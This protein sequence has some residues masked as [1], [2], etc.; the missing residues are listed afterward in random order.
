MN[1]HSRYYVW[2][3]SLGAPSLAL[4]ISI[5]VAASTWERVRTTPAKRTIQV[6]GSATKR[7]ISDLI[8]WKAE[9]SAT[10]P[11]RVAAYRDLPMARHDM[12]VMADPAGQIEAFRRFV[13]LERELLELLGRKLEQDQAMAG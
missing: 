12:Q 13:A 7:I 11:D 5:W 4:I 9:L 3:F 10:A 8:E 1:G 2:L 6:T